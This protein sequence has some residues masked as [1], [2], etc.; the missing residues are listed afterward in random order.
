MLSFSRTTGYA[1]LALACIGSW[2]GQLVRSSQIHECTGIPTPYLRKTLFAL[3][4]FGLIQAKRGYQGGFVLKRP[5]EEITLLDV[6]RAVEP[7]NSARDCLLA[8]AG[9]SDE[10]PCPVHGFWKEIRAQIEAELRSITV[11]QAAESVR[12]ARWGRLT[13]CCPPTVAT[14]PCSTSP[15]KAGKPRK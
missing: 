9:C 3:V 12:A 14:A 1:I 8:L 11:A 4:R 10:N 6:V 5:P 13:T 7:D 15:E 2:K